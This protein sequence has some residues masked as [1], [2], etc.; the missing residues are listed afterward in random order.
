MNEEKKPIFVECPHCLGLVEVV[1]LRC[2]I[3]R[4]ASFKNGREID[5]HLKQAECELLVSSSSVYGCG[6]PFSVEVQVDGR[7]ISRACEYI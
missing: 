1:D 4:H 5:P 3:F 2:G 6:K 7:Y